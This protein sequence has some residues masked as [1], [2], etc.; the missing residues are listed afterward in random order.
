MH[1]CSKFK[2]TQ[3][4][5]ATAAGTDALTNGC[6][7]LKNAQEDQPLLVAAG[8]LWLQETILHFQCSHLLHL[9]KLP[10]FAPVPSSRALVLYS[11]TKAPTECRALL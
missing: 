10:F 3:A 8:Q 2:F 1:V 11:M 9:L 5:L 4:L 6:L 7:S